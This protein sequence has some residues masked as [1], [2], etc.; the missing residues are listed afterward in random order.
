[1]FTA[2]HILNICYTTLQIP[3][4]GFGSFKIE[5]LSVISY[6]LTVYGLRHV[7]MVYS[8]QLMGI[9]CSL[10]LCIDCFCK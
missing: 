7:L 1:M 5:P 10:L 3:E 9:N 8:H 6:Q 2:L 4:K